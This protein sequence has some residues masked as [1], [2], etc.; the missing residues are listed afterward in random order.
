MLLGL[1][2][3]EPDA[4]RIFAGLG[5]AVDAPPGASTW[6]CIP[7]TH[8]P[9]LEIEVDLVDELV[10]HHGLDRLPMAASLPSEPPADPDRAEL[11]R[12]RTEASLMDALRELGLHET[13]S[14]VFT[15][16]EIAD[17]VGDI[18]AREAVALANPMR[19]EASVLRTHMLPGLL[20]ALAVDVARHAREVALFERGR[21]YGF[22]P[23]EIAEGTPTTRE[24]R[25]LPS[26]PTR[27]AVLRSPG[28]RPDPKLDADAIGRAGPREL[29]ALLV[30]ALARLGH[31]ARV[32]PAGNP[33]AWLHP[34]A[35]AEIAALVDGA[36]RLVGRFGRVHPSLVRRWDLPAAAAPVYG[37]LWLECVPPPRVPTFAALP[38]FPATARDLS[39]DLADAVP[40]AVVVD[41]I[42]QAERAIAAEHDSSASDAAMRSDPPR[43]ATG[44]RTASALELLEDW[45][46]AGVAARRRALLVRLHYRAMGRSV[47]DTEVQDL[48]RA[49]TQRALDDLRTHDPD[50]KIR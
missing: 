39:L 32:V 46:G 37:E 48:H 34:G 13:I 11:A 49:L 23:H 6:H 33:V 50:V 17:A 5:I 42:V 45:R 10:R 22:V 3:P 20:D 21:I 35:Q 25:K 1:D 26:E 12:R 16:P 31:T 14:S 24:D 27:I 36:P 8:R 19:S 38:R 15:R 40:A 18:G 2:V 41:A 28:P 44:D 9:D 4:R 7:P 43:L 30:D 29:G 47:T